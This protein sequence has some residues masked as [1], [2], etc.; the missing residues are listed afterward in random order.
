MAQELEGDMPMPSGITHTVCE[1]LKQLVEGNFPLEEWPLFY[2]DHEQFSQKSLLRFSVVFISG[3][4]KLAYT[5]DPRTAKKVSI[6]SFPPGKVYY[7][8]YKINVA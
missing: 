3:A 5:P 2:R 4:V 1:S 8:N 7:L 6:R